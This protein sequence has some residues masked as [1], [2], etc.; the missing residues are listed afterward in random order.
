VFARVVGE[1]SGWK[2]SEYFQGAMSIS[3]LSILAFLA[4]GVGGECLKKNYFLL[5]R[6]T[7]TAESRPAKTQTP[8]N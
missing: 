7:T 2:R 4:W 6:K 8:K 1:V 5:R 3:Y